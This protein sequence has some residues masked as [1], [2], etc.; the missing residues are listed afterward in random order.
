MFG[1]EI[2]GNGGGRQRANNAMAD[3]KVIVAV[4]AEKVISRTALAWA[5]THVVHAG[6]RITLLAVFS[7]EKTGILS[8]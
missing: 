4:K 6:D 2:E 8:S 3:N 7:G 5:L 1:N